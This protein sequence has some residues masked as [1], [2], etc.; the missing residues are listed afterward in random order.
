V[1]SRRRTLSALAPA[2]LVLLVLAGC[3]GDDEPTSAPVSTLTVTKTVTAP[4]TTPA[5]TSTAATP[6]TPPDPDA[7]LSLQAAERVLDARGYAPLGERD[8]RPGQALKV[9]LGVSQSADPRAEQAFFFVGDTFIGTDTKDPSAAIEVAAQGGDSVTLR[10]ALYRPSD[11]ID[12][13]TGGAADVTYAWDGTRLVPQDPIPS[14][15]SGAPLSR[16]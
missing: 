9:L 5:T 3:G 4:A 11:A 2:A 6:A 15:A 14:A 16:R 13:P 10:Y 12:S 1:P 7:P 8:W